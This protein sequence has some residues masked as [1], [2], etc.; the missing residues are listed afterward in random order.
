[1]EVVYSKDS[2]D[3]PVEYEAT[4][5]IVYDIK[6]KKIYIYGKGKV[7]YTTISLESEKIVYDWSNNLVSAEGQ[8]DT[9]GNPFGLPKFADASQNF[10][11]DRMKY[12]FVTKKGVVYD[13]RSKQDDIYIVSEVAKF[14]SSSEKTIDSTKAGNTLYSRNAI[15]TT[16]NHDHPHFGLRS[17]KQKI[18]PNKLIVVGP[19]YLEVGGVPTPLFLP[20]GFFPITQRR[21]AGLLIPQNYD[22]SPLLGGFGLRD[23][24]WFQPLGPTANLS[25][26][27]RIYWSGTWGLTGRLEYQKRYQHQGN[28]LVSFDKINQRQLGQNFSTQQQNFEIRITHNQDAKAHPYRRIGGSVNIVSNSTVNNRFIA[29]NA[30]NVLQNSLNSNFTYNYKFPNSP[31]NLSAGLTHSQILA[32]RTMSI[33]FPNARLTMQQINPFKRKNSD[34]TKEKWFEKVTLTYDADF[35]NELSGIDSIFFTSKNLQNLRLGLRQNATLN[36]NVRVLKYFN[37]VPNISYAETWNAKSRTFEFNPDF[38]KIDTANGSITQIGKLDTIIKNTFAPYRT[39]NVGASIGTQIFGKIMFRKGFIRG[40]RH[41]IKPDISYNFTPNYMGGLFNYREQVRTDVRDIPNNFRTYTRFDESV[42]GAPPTGA[43]A[44]TIGFNLNNI[45][46]AKYYS[47]KDSTVKNIKLLD[48]LFIN[49][50]YNLAADSLNWNPVNMSTT[51]RLFKGALNINTGASFSVYKQKETGG[52]INKISFTNGGPLL[53]P[54]NLAL[55]TGTNVTFEK[56]R[57]FFEGKKTDKEKSA[58]TIK[59]SNNLFALTD[60]FSLNMNIAGGLLP[61]SSGKYGLTDF[62]IRTA[63][64]VALSP[65]WNFRVGNIGYN[66]VRNELSFP[67]LGLIRDLHCWQMEINWLP[68]RGSYNFAIYVKPGSMGFLRLPYQRNNLDNLQNER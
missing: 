35:R 12:N 36:T 34:G 60:Q 49:S 41:T 64:T 68:T 54:T 32:T 9:L 67:D 44:Q 26:L 16:C 13:A 59:K 24:G 37:F 22:Y 48:N 11:A 23:L 4:D 52:N 7:S 57:T 6:N 15:F 43:S 46:D 25:L 38:V 28:V 31:F 20:F 5:S 53:V 3:A 19:S 8:L 17:F 65:K 39:F 61:S 29:N 40:I 33:S 56:I 2:L 50:G 30:A 42:F 47:R 1:V 66:F 58:S 18:I 63:G 21:A 14:V 27:G 45:F 10:V 55:S 51:I 62:E